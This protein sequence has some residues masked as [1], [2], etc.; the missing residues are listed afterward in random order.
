MALLVLASASPRRAELLTQIGVPFES[1]P[2]DLDETPLGNEQPADYV[3]RLALA[4]AQACRQQLAANVALSDDAV[5]LGSDTT[6]VINDEILGKPE[7]AEHSKQMLQRLSART[8][9]VITAVAVLS[10]EQQEIK[11][12]TTDV[13]FKTL[14]D[15]EIGKYWLSGE[16]CDKAGSY[17]IQGLGA[18]FVQEIHGS[19]S[20]V[21]GLPL[22]ETAELLRKV[23]IDVWQVC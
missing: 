23:G 8:H 6:V 12:V 19:Y 10:G 20:A 21:V 18:V 7:N 14:S 13:V 1:H 9:Q 15:D 16:P 22:M 4:K 17:G 11:T 2:V 5:V 3:A